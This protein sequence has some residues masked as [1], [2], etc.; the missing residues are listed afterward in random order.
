[1]FGWLKNKFNNLLPPDANKSLMSANFC[2]VKLNTKL[3]VPENMI[4]YVCYKDKTYLELPAGTHFL[5]QENL[6]NL[7]KKQHLAKSLKKVK[8]DLFFVNLSTFERQVKIK[9]KLLISRRLSRVELLVNF[10]I[11]VENA[12]AFSKFILSEMS[13]PN[14]SKT[15]GVVEGYFADFMH[16][17][18]LKKRFNS[19]VFEQD[20]L[21]ELTQKAQT[22]FEIGGVK[23][24]NIQLE[25]S[26]QKQ[27][28]IQPNKQLKQDTA[29][30]RKTLTQ[31]VDQ[32]N[33]NDYNISKSEKI[34][35]QEKKNICPNCKQN[36]VANSWF[37][38]RCGFKT[39]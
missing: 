20:I 37:C 22:F 2:T 21:N 19:L 18:L 5:N 4:C 13:C 36:I 27:K 35:N 6:K 31:T 10:K 26:P 25:F 7:C 3:T 33:K 34:I 14:A 8:V 30:E 12:D 38:H 32:S 1:M 11:R 39:K 29:V 24:C 16:K 28:F 15:D 17:F 9:E 23:L